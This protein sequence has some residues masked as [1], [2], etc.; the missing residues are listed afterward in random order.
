MV[1]Y[2][3]YLITLERASYDNDKSD[4]L[5]KD[6]DYGHRVY[7]FDAISM[8]ICKKLRGEKNYSCDSYYI[9]NSN[10]SFLIEFKNQAE[11]NIDRVKLKNKIY[12]SITTLAMNENLSPKE[13]A[14][15]TS[16]IIVYNNAQETVKD[17]YS[18]SNSKA[19]SKLSRK[20][21]ELAK[22]KDLDSFEKKFDLSKLKGKLFKEVYT[23]DKEDFEKTFIEYLFGE[24]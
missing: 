12:D 5:I 8:K 21:S 16:V 15:R 24:T 18:Y 3:N 9:K 1:E 10:D 4:S 6:E 7:N 13:I 17:E 19:M 14:D 20:L 23:V 2:N 22:K 11:G